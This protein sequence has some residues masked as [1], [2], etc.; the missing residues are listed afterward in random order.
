MNTEHGE[1]KTPAS[2]VRRY[3]GPMELYWITSDTGY[4]NKAKSLYAWN[5]KRSGIQAQAF[6]ADRIMVGSTSAIGGG[7]NLQ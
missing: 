1:K 7:V 2:T 6:V 3:A 5:V 4:L